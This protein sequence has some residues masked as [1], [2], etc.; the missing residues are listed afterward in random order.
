MTK[1][2]KFGIK[3]LEFNG[4]RVEIGTPSSSM[5]QPLKE[6]EG[7]SSKDSGTIVEFGKQ[8]KE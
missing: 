1:K 7:I 3:S 4:L 2:N 6:N 8:R 5:E